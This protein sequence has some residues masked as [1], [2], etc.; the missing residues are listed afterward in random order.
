[1]DALLVGQHDAKLGCLLA[2]LSRQ[3]VYL[4]GPPGCGKSAL[5]TGLARVAGARGVTLAL[6]RDLRDADLL[7]PAA[8]A[9]HH[10][11]AGER[12][13]LS[14]A[15]GPLDHAELLVLDDLGRAPTEALLP[16]LRALSERRL[17]GRRLGLEC[18]LATAAPAA[19]SESSEPLEPAT[20]DRFAVQL[21]LR[22]LL[23]S[24][25]RAP[26]RVVLEGFPT[27]GLR[28]VAPSGAP[29]GG[30]AI[31]TEARHALQARAAAMVL[32]ADVRAALV[33]LAG[34]LAALHAPDG[35]ASLS[36]RSLAAAA[37]GLLRAH[38]LLRGAERVERAD[39]AAL[40]FMLG[41]RVPES[42]LPLAEELVEDVARGRA[43][44]DAPANPASARAAQNGPRADAAAGPPAAS[45]A[46]L[47]ALP[48]A[49]PAGALR[50]ADVSALLRALEGR[51]EP[52]R[53]D[54]GPD[55]GGS[56]RRQARLS[57]LDELEDADVVEGLLFVEGS[58]PGAPRVL[59]RQRRRASGA[60]AVLRDVSA[61]ME[62]ALGLAASQVV[63]G[64]VRLGARRRMR[65]GYL[66][67]HHDA[68][69]FEAGGAF[70]HRRYGRLLAL[71]ARQ[72]AEGRTSYEA[73][74]RAALASFGSARGGSRHV[75][76]LTDGRPIVGDPSV[77]RERA[78]ARRLGVRVHTVF[79]GSSEPPA[80]LERL[81][82]ETG[83]RA[84]ALEPRA[85]PGAFG[86]RLRQERAP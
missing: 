33:A 8:L 32:P 57:R 72:R 20:L 31:D 85:L 49:P 51:I 2:L 21:R 15:P 54:P 3:H 59:Q 12:I 79:M 19:A 37:P 52:G 1:M 44:P 68:E 60:L 70:F 5:A 27:A 62:G 63:A 18:A 39:L 24:G 43:S 26:A 10:G 46:S 34:R 64:L 69:P 81:A 13:S 86:L 29:A 48:S 50:L 65:I 80:V 71:A 58:L 66:E 83:G 30:A 16:L 77:A 14:R 7:G 23:T 67:F 84:F 42:L 82:R 11:P 53:V 47:R 38:A 22:G 28:G 9:R 76:L 45:E 41:R 6:H 17:A 78:L 61:S 73:P 25:A 74:L 4:E 35:R 55:P 36:D 56:P 75:V 40:R